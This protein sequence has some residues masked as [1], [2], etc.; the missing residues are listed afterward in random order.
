[1]PKLDCLNLAI[2]LY[3]PHIICI[4]ES[5]LCQDISDSELFISG[6]QLIRFDRNRHGGGI[7]AYVDNKF[8]VSLD[9]SPPSPLELMSFS[10]NVNNTV[11]HVCV[12][13]RPPS[14]DMFIFDCLCSYFQSLDVIHFSNFVCLGDFNVNIDNVTHP[15]FS[16]LFNFSSMFGLSRTV[17]GP[18][19]SYHN[20]SVSTIDL[21]FVPD[22]TSVHKCETIP[23]LGN[24]DHN[25]ILTNLKL[26]SRNRTPIQPCKERLVWRYDHADWVTACHLIE[27]Y[28]WN[29]ILS[30]DID[31]VL[32]SWYCIFMSIMKQTIPNSVIRT[33][34]NL[35]WLSKSIIQSI[36]RRN[37]LF[38][39]A[40]RT[41]DFTKYKR[42][43]NRTLERLRLAKRKYLLQLNPKHPKRFWKTMKFLNRKSKSVPTLKN[44]S[45]V[46]C[47]SRDKANM[48]NNFF[49]NC[50]NTIFPPLSVPATLPLSHP[51]EEILCTEDEIFHLLSL[52]DVTKASGPDGISPKMLKYTA[53]SIAPI[54]TK[55][56]NLSIISSKIP[57]CWKQAYVVPSGGSRGGAWGAIAPPLG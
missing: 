43:R 36:R 56:F 20:G 15:L 30:D 27:S 10:V 45:E 22:T 16:N 5:W 11:L 50:F 35:P 32:D 26:T 29:S 17:T 25:G 44:D 13:Y 38:K 8:T 41:G 31:Q 34:R 49:A 33:K 47:S 9:P 39:Q 21:V 57:L 40:K 37:K 14:S 51:S 23:P 46:A 24:S 28:D 55:I 53:A 19:H 54:V 3:H 6:Y 2:S 18:T 1:M 52:L 7:L 42:A 12:F 48:L 4:V